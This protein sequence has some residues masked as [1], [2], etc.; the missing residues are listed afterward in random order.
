MEIGSCNA[1]IASIST[2]IDGSIKL[3]LEINPEEQAIISK[4]LKLWSINQR[5]ITIGMVQV[6][7]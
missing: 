5:L 6:D 4:L 2:K 7:E 1:L 3:T